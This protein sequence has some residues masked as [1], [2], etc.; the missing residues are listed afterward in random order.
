LRGEQLRLLPVLLIL[1]VAAK[2]IYDLTAMPTSLFAL[3]IQPDGRGVHQAVVAADAPGVAA[4]NQ[5]VRR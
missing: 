4:L 1:A 3:T 5:A 2:L